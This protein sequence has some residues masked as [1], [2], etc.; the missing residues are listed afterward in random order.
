MKSSQALT[1]PE[2]LVIIFIVLVLA[3]LALPHRRE[4]LFKSPLTQALSNMKQLY[5]VAQ[6]MAMD[7][8]AAEDTNLAWPGDLGGSFSNWVKQAVPAY[9]ATN[10]FDK[11]FSAPEK[12]ARPGTLP[13]A[14]TNGILMY[15]VS[16]NSA[17]STVI[18]TTANFT[19]TPEGGLRPSGWGIPFGTRNFVVFRKG[20]DGAVLLAK[21]A[22]NTNVVGIFAPLCH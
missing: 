15:A 20:G 19:N 1:I 5:L 22:G 13:F 9:L 17:D 2:L 16:S 10:D 18:F 11:L 4:G 6:R 3:T 8:E 14:N 7:G 21:Q 12:A